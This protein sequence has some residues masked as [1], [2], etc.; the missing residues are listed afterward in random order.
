MLIKV[1]E[2]FMSLE[3]EMLKAVLASFNK[4]AAEVCEGQQWDM[5]FETTDRVSEKQYLDM[6][7]L[8]TAVLLGFSLELGALLANAPKEDVQ[9]LRAFGTN[10]GIGFQLKDDLLD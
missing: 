3:P 6:I 1:Y 7:R 9:A 5:E 8:K 2:M 10:M 4:C